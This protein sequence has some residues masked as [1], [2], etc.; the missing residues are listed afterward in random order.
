[1]RIL[2][3]L[4]FFE[5]CGG[6]YS[7][8]LYLKKICGEAA[9][10]HYEMSRITRIDDRYCWA[11]EVNLFKNPYILFTI[12]KV[13]CISAGIVFVFSVLISLG[14]RDFFFKGFFE[15]LGV[16]VLIT[17]GLC[18]LGAISYVI[19]AL[20]LGK[21]YCVCFCMDE[22]GI[23][24]TQMDRQAEI[25]ELTGA[26]V[27]L[28]GTFAGKPGV[29][30]TGILAGARSSIS[31]NFKKVKRIRS[32][33]DSCTIKLDAPFSHNQ[34]YTAPEDFDFVLQYIKNR[35]NI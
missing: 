30:G 3:L 24:H 17:A 4:L 33:P 10:R 19:Y 8:Y 15:M 11:C 32:F 2:F 20:I 14:E 13:L 29:A 34:V 16:F 26:I 12:L 31:T 27:A 18:L 5:I 21:K 1:M 22:N 9:R 6:M 7:G 23:T 28:A 25:A 35:V